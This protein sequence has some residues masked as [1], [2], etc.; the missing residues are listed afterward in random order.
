MHL[1]IIYRVPTQLPGLSLSDPRSHRYGMATIPWPLCCALVFHACA[2]RL[3]TGAQGSDLNDV[4]SFPLSFWPRERLWRSRNDSPDRRG[5]PRTGPQVRSAQ[6][7]IG[8]LRAL[9][10]LFGRVPGHAGSRHPGG[11][12]QSSPPP[13]RLRLFRRRCSGGGPLQS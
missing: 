5:R 3:V 12:G 11:G 1:S 10:A 4:L 8:Q 13:R 2:L 9:I 6:T 7:K